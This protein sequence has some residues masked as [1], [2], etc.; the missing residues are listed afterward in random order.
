MKSSTGEIGEVLLSPK[1]LIRTSY[2]VAKDLSYL[3]L[4]ET[5]LTAEFMT[6]HNKQGMNIIHTGI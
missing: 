4:A 5:L 3:A 6:R 2:E 1:I